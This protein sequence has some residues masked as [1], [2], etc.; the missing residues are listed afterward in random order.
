MAFAPASG[1]ALLADPS[2]KF[3]NE[4]GAPRSNTSEETPVVTWTDDETAFERTAKEELVGED[5]EG[6]DTELGM[7]DAEDETEY[8]MPFPEDE[9]SA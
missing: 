1:G 2:S 3:C 7:I 6:I 5:E 9:A 4:C 8:L